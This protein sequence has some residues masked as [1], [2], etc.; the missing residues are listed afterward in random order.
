MTIEQ[1]IEEAKKD[2][3]EKFKD[4]EASAFAGNVWSIADN[5]V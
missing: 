2:F 4:F 5:T 1:A 3:K